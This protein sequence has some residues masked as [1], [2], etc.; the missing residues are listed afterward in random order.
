[1]S[2]MTTNH[3]RIRE[4]AEARGA[5]PVTVRR[6]HQGDDVGII[7]LDFPGYG[8]GEDLEAIS[9]DEFFEKF[10]KGQLALVY[11]E[12]TADGRRSNYNKLVRR[13]PEGGGETR[14]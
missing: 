10:E 4:W 8:G 11:Q 7:R 12:E 5:H 14:H 3:Q 1:M 2:Q 9:W 13:E 6:V